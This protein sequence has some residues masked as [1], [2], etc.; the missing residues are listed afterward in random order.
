MADPNVQRVLGR[1]AEVAALAGLKGR[2]NE[3]LERFEMGFNLDQG[4]TQMA[5]VRYVGKAPGDKDAVMFFSPARIVKKGIFS[6]ISRDAAVE[7]LKLNAQ[8]LFARYSVVENDDEII[9][10]SSVDHIL[11]TLDPDEFGMTSWA[12]AASADRYERQ[13]G[14]DAF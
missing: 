2:L 14:G 7:L 9:V 4:R 11:D 8:L 1:V 3:Q 13:H 10:M 5:Y 6:G 12:V